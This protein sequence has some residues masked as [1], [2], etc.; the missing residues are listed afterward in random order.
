MAISDGGVGPRKGPLQSDDFIFHVN[1]PTDFTAR[2]AIRSMSSALTT[3]TAEAHDAAKNGSMITDKASM[4]IDNDPASVDLGAISS[5]G[6]TT[7]ASHTP[8]GMQLSPS[9]EGDMIEVILEPGAYQLPLERDSRGKLKNKYMMA[10]GTVVNGKG[11]GRGRPGFKRGPRKSALSKEVVDDSSSES[12]SPVTPASAV[13]SIAQQ[14]RSTP[15][16]RKRTVSDLASTVD[17]DADDADD[18]SRASTPEYNPA[19]STQTRSG[20]QS[21]KPLTVVANTSNAAPTISKRPSLAKTT[22]S[23]SVKRHPKIKAKVYRG[24][25]QF[26]LCEHC[27]RSNGPPGNLIVFCDACNKCWHQKCHEPKIAKEVVSDTKAEWFCADCD[28]ILHGKKKSKPAS[29]ASLDVPPVPPQP[30]VS[31][32]P[33]P[34]SQLPPIRY[35]MPWIPGMSLTL[36][37]QKAYLNSLP[38]EKLVDIVLRSAQLAPNMPI[39]ETPYLLVANPIRQPSPVTNSQLPPHVLPRPAHTPMP[40]PPL[41]VVAS[42]EPKSN[43]STSGPGVAIY[44]HPTAGVPSKPNTQPPKAGEEIDEGYYD[45]FDEMALLYPKPGEG[46]YDLMLPPESSDLNI[47]LEGPGCKN[48]SHWI[49]GQGDIRTTIEP[50][51]AR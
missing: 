38:K 5:R 11:L 44:D 37:Q 46:V 41:A 2:S 4:L 29:K 34:I 3:Q 33:P 13:P 12:G 16:K 1:T 18:A 21:Q 39:F 10:D 22:S 48:F 15:I 9:S 19:A 24:R 8:D 20:R 14:S 36:D 49:R 27:L 51:S 28:R 23:P 7:S 26:A 40:P 35:G 45:D 32:M 31:N 6:S 42:N 43:I 17:D 47:L 50:L 25:E 30:P